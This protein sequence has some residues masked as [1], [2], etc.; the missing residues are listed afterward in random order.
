[1][2]GVIVSAHGRA[3]EELMNTCEM[4]CGTQKNVRT[5]S[6]LPGEGIEDVRRKYEEAITSLD[7]TDGVLFLCD[8]FGGSPFNAA[9]HMAAS[10]ANY[11]VV[12]GVNLPMLADLM[13]SHKNDGALSMHDLI[14]AVQEAGRVGIGTFHADDLEDTNNMP[15]D[16]L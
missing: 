2:V 4:I 1:M 5:V 3:A 13:M 8:L 14:A 10:H 9:S 16:E 6:F 7:T 12:T 11:G 15:D